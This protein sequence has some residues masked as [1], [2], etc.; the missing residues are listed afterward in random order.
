MIVVRRSICRRVWNF[1]F[2]FR[3]EYIFVLEIEGREGDGSIGVFRVL[4][5]RVKEE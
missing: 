2:D 5:V 4:G 3:K 1:F